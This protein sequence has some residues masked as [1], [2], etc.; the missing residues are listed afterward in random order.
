MKLSE[1]AAALTAELRGTDSE[2]SGVAGTV[3]ATP[4]SLLFAEDAHSLDA[5]LASSAAAVIVSPRLAPDSCPKPLLVA[6][7]PRLIFARAAARRPEGV[8]G[9]SPAPAWERQWRRR[10]AQRLSARPGCGHLQ[11]KSGA[12]PAWR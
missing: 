5:A 6:A 3:N 1:I 10:H 7:Q 11:A 12:T 2:V 8:W 4:A 9:M